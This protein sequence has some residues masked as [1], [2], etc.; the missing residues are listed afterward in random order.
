MPYLID[1]HNLIPH[2]PGL[3]LQDLDDEL[4]LIKL[5]QAFSQTTGKRAE[6]FFDNAAPGQAGRRAFGSLTAFFVSQ[7]RTADSAIKNRLKK[8][9]RSAHNWTVVSAD[10]E[11]IAAA[12]EAR[13]KTRSSA[14]FASL[15]LTRSGGSDG[16][17]ESPAGL[18][19]AE[20]ETWLRLFSDSKEE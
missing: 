10:R 7:G 4:E 20:V 14:E 12:K 11:V 17:K 15:L 2:I 19:E 16:E 8:L 9:G 13:A 6:V 3:T 18:S 5:L 1:G